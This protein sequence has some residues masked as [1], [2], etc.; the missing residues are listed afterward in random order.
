MSKE[1]SAI[2]EDL[3]KLKSLLSANL[4]IKNHF[5]E[6]WIAKNIECCVM[7]IVDDLCSKV[8]KYSVPG[9]DIIEDIPS[10]SHECDRQMFNC[11]ECNYQALTRFAVNRHHSK[12]H[13]SEGSLFLNS[14]YL[15]IQFDYLFLLRGDT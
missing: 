4:T 15:S 2:C 7:D 10:T 11:K 9:P 14:K 1:L 12:H 3:K 5:N 8:A 6:Y 13:N